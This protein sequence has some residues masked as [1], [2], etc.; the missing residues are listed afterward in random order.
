[1]GELIINEQNLT[2]FCIK[3][4]EWVGVSLEDAKIV[5]KILTTNEM[6]GIKSHGVI[7]LSTY[8][9]KIKFGTVNINAT[10]DTIREG[11]S[12]AL[13][14][15]NSGMGLVI[16]YKAM[17]IAINKAKQNEIGM[18]CVRNS[19]HFSAAGY[20]SLMCAEENMIGIAMSNADI[21]MTIPGAIGR[22][23]GNNPFSLA[24]PVDDEISFCLD[25][26]MSKVA[27]GK[28]SMACREN[29]EIPNDWVVDREGKPTT[30]PQDYFKGG[31]LLPFGDYKGYG[32][33][34]MVECLSA[35]LSGTAMHKTVD[36]CERLQ[37]NRA[38]GHFFLAINIDQIIPINDFKNRIDDFR[39]ELINSPKAEGVKNIFLPGEIERLNEKESREKGI[40]IGKT[41]YMELRELA[42]TL[43]INFNF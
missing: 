16:A 11:S 7:L 42:E 40:K 18:V 3:A 26:A 31:A 17:K 9:Q 2:E 22:V 15:G 37:S 14:N 13:V 21:N 34:V 38:I 35:G 32:L 28:I 30:D 43:G 5:A 4:L 25:I 27:A 10:L 8:I 1:M 33:A 29:R 6:R 39:K 41:T 36:P 12:W 20:Y 19:R 24:F 23:I